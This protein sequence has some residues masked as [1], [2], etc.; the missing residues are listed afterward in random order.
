MVNLNRLNRFG[1]TAISPPCVFFQFTTNKHE[2][3][4]LEPDRITL[5]IGLHNNTL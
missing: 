4:L 1:N 3:E 5:A 2:N